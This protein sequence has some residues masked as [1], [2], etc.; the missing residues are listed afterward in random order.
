MGSN[1]RVQLLN[2]PNSET[3][4]IMYFQF[5]T[6]LSV[7]L[8]CLL[9][10]GCSTE[11]NDSFQISGEWSIG[12]YSLYSEVGDN[13]LNDQTFQDAG[14]FLFN[15]DG[16]G[17]V[18]LDIPGSSLPENQPITWSFN[19][20]QS[21]LSIDYKTGQDVFLYMVSIQSENRVSLVHTAEFTSD[22][23]AGISKTTMELTRNL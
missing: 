11:E 22:G 3:M 2:Q 15:P 9:L 7:I 1:S 13:L 14:L 10:N 5:A 12:S 20:D 19:Q 8:I 6:L 23:V 18:T 21:E 17:T 16:S 4:K